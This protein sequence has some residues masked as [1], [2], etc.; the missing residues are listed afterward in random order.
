MILTTA[1]DVDVLARSG[2]GFFFMPGS[3]QNVCTVVWD[4]F[5][6]ARGPLHKHS[7][8]HSRTTTLF[9]I[10]SAIFVGSSCWTI[11]IIDSGTINRDKKHAP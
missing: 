5:A 2:D 4:G 10:R 9:L 1:A 8:G 3:K 6:Y 7:R 11:L